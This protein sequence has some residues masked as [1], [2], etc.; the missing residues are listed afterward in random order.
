MF[1][2][3]YSF[4][5][6]HS[7]NSGIHWNF[8]DGGTYSTTTSGGF[9]PTHTYTAVGVYV[10]SAYCD[11]NCPPPP[12]PHICRLVDTIHY[13]VPIAANF[14]ASVNCEKVYLNN[15]SSVIS[16]CSIVGYAWSA[17]GPGSV[18]FSNTAIA[19]PVL[20]VGASG[21]Y[22]VTLTV[23]SSCSGCTATITLPV[24][25][26]LPSATFTAP[27]PVCAG[28]P[29][30]LSAPGGMSNYLWNFGDTY[31]NYVWR[32]KAKCFG[33]ASKRDSD[34]FGP[35]INCVDRNSLDSAIRKEFKLHRSRD[36]TR[37]A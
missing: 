19:S 4:S 9:T 35:C 23:T 1:S 30:A 33:S 36:P 28:T 25:V 12:T 2:A 18:S 32:R 15:L 17:T 6:P 27:T 11:V 24:T 31:T 26:S 29:I 37:S 20:T 14:G 8:G 7:L 22:N 10:V 16:G 3:V 34:T 13:I 21:T 5:S